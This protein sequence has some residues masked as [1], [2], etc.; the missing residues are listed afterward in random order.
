MLI[1]VVVCK[2][3]MSEHSKHNLDQIPVDKL[4]QL[5]VAAHLTQLSESHLRNLLSWGRV[6]GIKL[7]TT[8]FTTKT[9][10]D[11]YLAIGNKPGPKPKTKAS[12][13]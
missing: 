2:G 3:Y 10:V 8:W 13:K 7:G 11:A 1:Q 4:L 6:E 5:K 9:A 12:M